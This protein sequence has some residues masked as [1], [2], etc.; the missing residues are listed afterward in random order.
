MGFVAPQWLTK[1][2]RHVNSI[3]NVITDKTMITYKVNAPIDI[4]EVI[5]LYKSCSLGNRR[6]VEERAVMAQMIMD[7]P[8]VVTAWDDDQLVGIA[9]TLTDY[10][11]AAYLSCLAVD[12]DYQNQGIGK[13][14]VEKTREELDPKC[15]LLL[16]SAPTATGYYP[17]LGFSSH[18]LA[19]VLYPGDELQG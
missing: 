6:P 16:I 14:L 17:K 15:F 10:C 8:L 12:E 5:T 13:K 2:N 11:Y 19:Y 1:A 9:R 4:D 3:R 18:P 7:A